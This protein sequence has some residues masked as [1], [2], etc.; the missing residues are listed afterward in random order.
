RSSGDGLGPVPLHGHYQRHPAR[1]ATDAPHRGSRPHCPGCVCVG[2][3]RGGVG[4]G[5]KGYQNGGEVV[6]SQGSSSESAFPSSQSVLSGT[7]MPF[8]AAFPSRPCRREFRTLHITATDLRQTGVDIGVITFGLGHPT[9]DC[10]LSKEFRR[11][12]GIP[13]FSRATSRIV[14]PV[15]WATRSRNSRPELIADD[16]KGVFFPARPIAWPGSDRKAEP[17]PGFT[18]SEDT[19]DR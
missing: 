14:R 16:E 11:S 19:S 1:P 2:G 18:C 8:L 7:T 17:R 6:P 13:D 12:S 9:C 5:E 10:G 3:L 15:A 4:G